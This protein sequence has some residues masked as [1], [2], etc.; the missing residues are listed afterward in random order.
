MIEE[1]QE[2]T[3][4]LSWPVWQ[5]HRRW[6]KGAMPPEDWP[7]IDRLAWQRGARSRGGPLDKLRQRVPTQG[8]FEEF[9]QSA[10]GRFLS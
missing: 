10:Y 1:Y 9:R 2:W 3:P 4:R 6:K 5:T 8:G 7:E